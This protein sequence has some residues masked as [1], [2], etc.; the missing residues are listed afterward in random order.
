LLIRNVLFRIRIQILAA[1][2]FAKTLSII[3]VFS[4]HA[5]IGNDV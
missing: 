4:V 3:I 5:V 2:L 1:K